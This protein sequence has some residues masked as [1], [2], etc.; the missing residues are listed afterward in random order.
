MSLD[1]RRLSPESKIQQNHPG[2]KNQIDRIIGTIENSGHLL[3][4]ATQIPGLKSKPI[5][6]LRISIGGFGESAARLIFRYDGKHLN[7]LHVYTKSDTEDIARSQILNALRAADLD[8]QDPDQ[9]D[10]DLNS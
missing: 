10:Q 7:P 1:E 4:N 3:Q 9:D 5:Y 8:E 6:K 2:A